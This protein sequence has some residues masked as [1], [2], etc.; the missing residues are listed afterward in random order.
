MQFDMTFYVGRNGENI[1][2]IVTDYTNSDLN[3]FTRELVDA[4]SNIPWVNTQCGYGCSD[5]A[6][7]T[8]AGYRA[9]FPF[10]SQ[11]SQSNPYIHTA[12]DTLANVDWQHAV[13]FSY[14]GLGYLIE[15]AATEYRSGFF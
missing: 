13:N 6:S 5:H 15:V 10:E 9:S 1:V 11:F 3:R 12:Q 8:Y 4:Y 7:W 14:L 2:G